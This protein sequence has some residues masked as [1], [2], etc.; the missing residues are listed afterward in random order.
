MIGKSPLQIVG[1]G[2]LTIPN[3]AFESLY[4]GDLSL[5]SWFV[6]SPFPFG[7]SVG[8]D[9]VASP[10]VRN[11]LIGCPAMSGQSMGLS[12]FTMERIALS[13]LRE[14]GKKE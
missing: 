9:C 6:G 2:L 10:G 5:A 1:C 4:E 3:E 8:N 7:N 13:S 12:S 11:S 14:R